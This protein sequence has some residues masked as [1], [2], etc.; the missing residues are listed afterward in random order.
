MRA[1]VDQHEHHVLRKSCRTPVYVNKYKIIRI[2]HKTNGS[3]DET[4]NVFRFRGN[5]RKHHHW[6]YKR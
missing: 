5:R 6:N 4:D 3:K 1:T 2:H